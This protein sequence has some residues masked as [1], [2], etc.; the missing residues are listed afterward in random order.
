MCVCAF[1]GD[2]IRELGAFYLCV[3]TS[4]LFSPPYLDPSTLSTLGIDLQAESALTQ[5]FSK[6]CLLFFFG[7]LRTNL[8]IESPKNRIGIPEIEK[9][10]AR[11]QREL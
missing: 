8:G 1:Q 9:E 3:L 7:V 4:R 2:L 10:D 5:T 11:P 6:I